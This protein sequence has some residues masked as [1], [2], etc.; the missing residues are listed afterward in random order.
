MYNRTGKVLSCHSVK[1]PAST[2]PGWRLSA[3]DRHRSLRSADVLTCAT[4]RTRTRLGDRRFSVAGPSL[5]N[6]LPVALRDTDISLNSLRDF[7]RHFGLYRAAAHSDWCFFCTVYKYSYLLTC[8]V[9]FGIMRALQ[10]DKRQSNIQTRSS[11][12]G[13]TLPGVK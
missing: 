13:H 6:S 10:T 7:W 5:W 1:R 3:L 2:V 9:F 4:N 8:Y 12:S 11:Q